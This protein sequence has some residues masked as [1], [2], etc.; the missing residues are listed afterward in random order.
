MSRC[1]CIT[2]ALQHVSTAVPK[3]NACKVRAFSYT[4]R[5]SSCPR[6][7]FLPYAHR[8]SS[9]PAHTHGELL[10]L[11]LLLSLPPT[12]TSGKAQGKTWKPR[13][14]KHR[15]LCLYLPWP[16]QPQQAPSPRFSARFVPQTHCKLRTPRQT[17][18]SNGAAPV[19]LKWERN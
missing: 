16:Q 17:R 8:C 9:R 5:S 7:H 19:P 12:Q 18:E 13:P 6:A 3:Q 15:Q 2:R 10:A 11:G 1:Y 4:S 14:G